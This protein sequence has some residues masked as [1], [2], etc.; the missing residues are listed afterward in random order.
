MS[1]EVRQSVLLD[2]Y[3]GGLHYG[4]N[5]VSLLKLQLVGAAPRDGA[6]NEILTDA[7]DDMGHNIAQLDFFDGSSQFVSR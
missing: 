4:D 3:L 5:G 2:H 1:S 7:D 6:F